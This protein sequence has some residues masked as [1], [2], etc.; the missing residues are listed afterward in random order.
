[1]PRTGRPSRERRHRRL[2]FVTP[3]SIVRLSRSRGRSRE[4]C[5][6]QE[7]RECSEAALNGRRRS[8]GVRFRF[9]KDKLGREADKL[10]DFHDACRTDQCQHLSRH[11]GAPTERNGARSSGTGASG[12]CWPRA[13]PV[14]LLEGG[15]LWELAG[16]RA[17][18]SPGQTVPDRKQHEAQ[19]EVAAAGRQEPPICRLCLGDFWQ[20]QTRRRPLA[21]CGCVG[22]DC[23][24]SSRRRAASLRQPQ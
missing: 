14:F 24:H 13:S 18:V 21:A 9:T 3:R 19:S 7:E 23:V 16:G 10:V 22:S 11:C 8:G 5:L 12:D 20:W 6:R 17:S 15:A 4:T 1:M 2:W